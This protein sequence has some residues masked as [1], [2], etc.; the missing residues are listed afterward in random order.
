MKKNLILFVFLWLLSSHVM[1]VEVTGV[2]HWVSPDYTRMVFDVSESVEHKVFSLEKPDRLVVDLLASRLHTE[3]PRTLAKDP[4]V[5]RIRS[6]TRNGS[7]LRVVFD[8]NVPVRPKSF[9]LKPNSRYGHRLVVDLYARASEQNQ[10]REVR[11]SLA[12]PLLRSRDVVI[13]IDAGHGGEDPGAKGPSGVYEKD[14][15][16]AIAQKLARL[17]DREPGMKAVLIRNGDYYIGLRQRMRKAHQQRAD[18]FVSI[19]A[20]AFKNRGA[21]GSSVFTLSQ[22]GASSEAARWLAHSENAA[23]LI[24]GVSLDDKDD[25]LASVLLDLSQAATMEASNEVAS[26]LLAELRQVGKMHKRHVQQAGF[27][28][29][30]SPD[31]PSVLVETAFISNPSE[32][33]KL[34]DSAH[35]QKLAQALLSGIRDY[36]LRSPPPGTLLAER[37]SYEHIIE[38]GDT[39]SD[40]AKQ[41]RVSLNDLRKANRLK[42]DRIRVGQVLRIPEG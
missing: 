22:R 41:Y 32:E 26:E 30:K 37:K 8:L 34:N 12:D 2:R 36:F 21:R 23:D 16:L 39:L 38:R 27:M 17:V 3:L 13:A 40:I 18:L 24:G 1:G 11:K 14:V 42:S 33:R 6:S 28:V 7:D 29:L 5:A 4:Y 31:I 10:V 35:Q 20:D 25:L 15:T 9:V 19:H